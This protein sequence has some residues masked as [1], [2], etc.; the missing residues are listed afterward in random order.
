MLAP[1]QQSPKKTGKTPPRR[2]VRPRPFLAPAAGF[3][4]ILVGAV[5][6]VSS[7]FFLF[8]KVA[9]V[10][11]IHPLFFGPILSILALVLITVVSRTLHPQDY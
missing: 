3:W 4:G 11:Q 7:H 8:R 9:Y 2:G 1:S 6:G 5:G 10:G